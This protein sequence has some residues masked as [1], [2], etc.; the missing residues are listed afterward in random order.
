M[1]R[2]FFFLFVIHCS[3]AQNYSEIEH[4][5]LNFHFHKTD[6]LIKN[7]PQSNHT[8]YY[9]HHK[10]F[11]QQFFYENNIEYF[12]VQSDKILDQ[13]QNSKYSEHWKN[14]FL[15][16]IYLERTLILFLQKSYWSAYKNFREAF[17]Y[18]QKNKNIHNL[19][20][21]KRLN[22]IMEIL[23]GSIPSKYKWLTD[24]L[25][26]TGDLQKGIQLFHKILDKTEIQKDENQVLLFYLS[27]HLFNDAQTAYLAIAKLHQKYPQSPFFN[28]LFG[29]LF[30]DKKELSIAK[31]KLLYCYQKSITN[32]DYPIYHLAHCYLYELQLD[33]AKFF[34]E[35]FIEQ[36]KGNIFKADA[37]YKLGVILS[38]QDKPQEAQKYF[39]RATQFSESISDKDLHA[40]NIS[41]NHIFKP[42]TKQELYLYQARWLFDGGFYIKALTILNAMPY[43][44]PPEIQIELHY[45]KARIYH[46]QK[47]YQQAL[48]SYKQV[49]EVNTTQNLWMKPYSAYF[50]A[51]LHE[52]KLDFQQAKYFFNKALSYKNYDFQ[53]SL[54]QKIHT[55]L[56]KLNYSR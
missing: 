47:K 28:Y 3:Y 33:S 54:E 46:E 2:F 21:P 19:I 42:L 11:Y 49:F 6:S 10:L 17:K 4:S 15:G 14:A 32:F 23:L 41:K 5:I 43:N 26:Y 29:I 31:Q 37:N 56:A 27:K 16:E 30:L 8:Y 25:G 52:E 53:T 12:L 48:E 34:F 7:L 22:A 50:I 1:K 36:K 39:Y 45:R 24:L 38:I 13:L 55:R 20:F 40:I 44:N 51:T 35:K 18:N 9:D